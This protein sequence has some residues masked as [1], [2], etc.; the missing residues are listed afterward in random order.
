[1][2]PKKCGFDPEGSGSK[3]MITFSLLENSIGIKGKPQML[4]NRGGSL[5]RRYRPHPEE[6]HKA[7]GLRGHNMNITG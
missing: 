2:P 3:T 1:M 6:H 5:N 7:P 4:K